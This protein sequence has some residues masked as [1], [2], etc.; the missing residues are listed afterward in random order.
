[1]DVSTIS[2]QFS[3]PESRDDLLVSE[4]GKY[5]VGKLVPVHQVGLLSCIGLN[6]YN[7]FQ[8]HF[9]DS[10]MRHYMPYIDFHSPS[11]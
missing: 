7:R 3:F 1:M 6:Y 8:L 2:W 9:L 5:S 4:T 11:L 10:Y